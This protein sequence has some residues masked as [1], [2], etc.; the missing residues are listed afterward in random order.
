MIYSNTL[1]KLPYY[2]I[3]NLYAGIALYS[4]PYLIYVDWFLIET[5]FDPE[6]G[7]TLHPISLSSLLLVLTIILHTLIAI[8]SLYLFV[9]PLHHLIQLQDSFN[10]SHVSGKLYLVMIKYSILYSCSIFSGL[11]LLVLSMTSPIGYTY[12]LIS[13]LTNGIVLILLHPI[14]NK[15]YKNLCCCAHTLCAIVWG[16]PRDVIFNRSTSRSKTQKSFNPESLKFEK[17]RTG[18]QNNKQSNIEQ[19]QETESNESLKATSNMNEPGEGLVVNVRNPLS[20]RSEDDIGVHVTDRGQTVIGPTVTGRGGDLG[21]GSLSTRSP[22][23]SPPKASAFPLGTGRSVRNYASSLPPRTPH[24]NSILSYTNHERLTVRITSLK[25]SKSSIRNQSIKSNTSITAATQCSALSPALSTLQED[26]VS[27]EL[28]SDLH[29]S[30]LAELKEECALEHASPPMFV[31]GP[32]TS[33]A[34]E[35]GLSPRSTTRLHSLSP[36]SVTS[37]VDVVHGPAGASRRLSGSARKFSMSIND[38]IQ[39]EVSTQKMADKSATPMVSVVVEPSL[40]DV[41]ESIEEEQVLPRSPTLRNVASGGDSNKRPLSGSIMQ[42]RLSTERPLSGS[43]M[44]GSFASPTHRSS[45][46][47]RAKHSISRNTTTTERI[48]NNINIEALW[49][50]THRISQLTSS[51]QQPHDVQGM[52]SGTTTRDDVRSL[53]SK[54]TFWARQRSTAHFGGT[55]HTKS[56]QSVNSEIA[57]SFQQSIIKTLRFLDNE[58]SQLF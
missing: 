54:S 27:H 4:I 40:P 47:D 3:I 11:I 26:D 5:R 30:N 17:S 31:R 28:Y 58:S 21:R 6:F 14:Q 15:L 9:F 52:L 57:E 49:N 7:C 36:R 37:P 16:A 35:C 34:L 2:H 29:D 18:T 51:Q 46:P 55:Q 48:L 41:I 38:A 19:H 45:N 43:M 8:Y 10:N 23:R 53:T 42:Q 12:S 50:S 33:L 44:S 24:S 25:S 32:S 1:F 39:S 13:S 22:P 20:A 56:W